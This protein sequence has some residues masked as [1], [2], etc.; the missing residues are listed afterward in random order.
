MAISIVQTLTVYLC[1]TGLMVDINWL[2]EFVSVYV[3]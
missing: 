2:L 1:I 3:F